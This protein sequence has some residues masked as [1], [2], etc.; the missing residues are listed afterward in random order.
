MP[1]V[2]LCL[3]YDG[4]LQTKYKNDTAKAEMS[5]NTINYPRG[6]LYFLKLLL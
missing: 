4:T 1:S 2:Q 5:R 6:V 3:G